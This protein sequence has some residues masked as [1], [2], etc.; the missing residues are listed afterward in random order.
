MPMC[1]NSTAKAD[2]RGTLLEASVAAV[3]AL[4]PDQNFDGSIIGALNA[5][6]SRIVDLWNA[7][8]FHMDHQISALEDQLEHDFWDKPQNPISILHQAQRASR[9]LTVYHDQLGSMRIDLAYGVGGTIPED[10]AI[11]IKDAQDKLDLLIRRADKVVRALL[12]SIAI[13]EGA[14]ASS[15]TAIALWFAP[16]SLSIS[17]VSI[18]GRSELGGKKY[19][20]MASIAVPLLLLVIAVANTSDRLMDALGRRRRG[21]ALIKLFKPEL[22]LGRRGV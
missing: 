2:L 11:D 14:K 19:W 4:P 21:R 16:L 1:S 7:A 10:L 22:K 20:I 18:D 8:T 12:A 5:S 17:L 6:M 15:L 13:G 3:K 9:R